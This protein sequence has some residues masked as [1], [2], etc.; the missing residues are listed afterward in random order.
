[1][2]RS[3]RLVAAALLAALAPP[4]GGQPGSAPGLAAP[5]VLSTLRRDDA[6]VAA[7]A[8]RLA[9]SGRP[10]CREAHPLTGFLFHHL[11]EYEPRDRPLMIGRYGLDRG[12][13][14]LTVLAGTPAAHAGLVAGDVLLSVNGRTFPSPARIAAEPSR[15]KWRPM[16]EQSEKLLEADLRSGPARLVVLRG[17]R[18][19]PVTLGSEPGC[20]GRVR[21]ARSTQMNAFSLRG[22]VVMTS[23]MLGYVRSEDE[24]AVVLGHELSHSI[25]G[26]QGLRDEEGILAGLGIKASAVWKREEAADRLGLRLMAAAGYDLDAAIPFWDRYLRAYDWFPQIFRSHPSRGARARI[27]REEIEAI[28]RQGAPEGSR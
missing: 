2:K 23:A 12:P 14:V 17:G 1:V 21:L 22:Y 18:E 11:A 13:G 10:L 20:I 6:R 7:V 3:L 16:L 28:R 25:L 19:L 26:H 24:L 8:Y 4:A 15:K 27:A 5:E 9:R